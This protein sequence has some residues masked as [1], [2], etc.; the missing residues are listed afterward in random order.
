MHSDSDEIA[1]RRIGNDVTYCR[2]PVMAMAAKQGWSLVLNRRENIQR[3]KVDMRGKP[4]FNSC[5]P[6]GKEEEY[7]KAVA[8][9]GGMVTMAMGRGGVRV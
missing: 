2:D 1:Q 6:M 3:E 4:V 9:S 8:D 5:A 7:E